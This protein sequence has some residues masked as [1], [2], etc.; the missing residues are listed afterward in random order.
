M[1]PRYRANTGASDK[2]TPIVTVGVFHHAARFGHGAHSLLGGRAAA[3]GAEQS[4]A[5]RQP[6]LPN[7]AW[8]VLTT[9]TRL[10]ILR[11]SIVYALKGQNHARRRH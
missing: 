11:V 8:R 6:G 3:T 7:K 4:K 10:N 2:K 1:A 5:S 9:A